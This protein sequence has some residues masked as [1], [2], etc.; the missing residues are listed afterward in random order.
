MNAAGESF[1][2]KKYEFF[3]GNE[4]R[5]NYRLAMVDKDGSIKYSPIR[6]ARCATPG[7]IRIIPNP[8]YNNTT[9][10]MERNDPA[11]AE[12]RLINTTGQVV[13]LQQ[14]KL[15][16]GTNQIKINLLNLPA[17]LYVIQIISDEINEKRSVIK[18][19]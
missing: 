15:I 10:Y 19:K 18:L 17:G 7:S 12:L 6:M 4:T 14:E 3:A 9:V 2:E 13:H 5:G 11:I 1:V 8:A 16:Q